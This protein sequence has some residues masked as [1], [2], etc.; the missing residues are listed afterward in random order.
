VDLSLW[1]F[2]TGYTYVTLNSW[3]NTLPFWVCFSRSSLIGN[4]SLYLADFSD[5]ARIYGRTDA[6]LLQPSIQLA[7]AKLLGEGETGEQE[8][9]IIR[10][11]ELIGHFS[12][13]PDHSI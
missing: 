10:D 8:I 2:A 12:L 11:Y 1:E 7:R 3:A 9:R 5:D 4:I 6:A 13:P